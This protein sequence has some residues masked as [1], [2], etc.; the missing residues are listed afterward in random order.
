MTSGT[1]AR[2]GLGLGLLERGLLVSGTVEGIGST[3]PRSEGIQRKKNKSDSKDTVSRN[4][5]EFLCDESTNRC[6]QDASC[7]N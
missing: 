5:G 4:C 1:R 6:A 7:L 2:P 3:A